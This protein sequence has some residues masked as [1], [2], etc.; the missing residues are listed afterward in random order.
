M[1][2]GPSS[3]T[4][5]K[6]EGGQAEEHGGEGK[7]HGCRGRDGKNSGG[8]SGCVSQASRTTRSTVTKM[9][10][11]QPEASVLFQPRGAG[12]GF[13]QLVHMLVETSS[14]EELEWKEIQ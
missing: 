10:V 2:S 9:V 1:H 8:H 6:G 7:G 5:R 13:L 14:R 12:S 3:K 11:L 4:V